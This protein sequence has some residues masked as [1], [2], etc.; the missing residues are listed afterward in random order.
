MGKPHASPDDAIWAIN[1]VGIADEINAMPDGLDTEMISAGKGLSRVLVSKII[2]AR[3]LAKR[4]ALLILSDYFNDLYL[5]DRANLIKMLTDKK[6]E[7]TLIVVSNDPLIMEACDRVV[8]LENGSITTQGRF[9]DL[10]RN[11]ELN[12]ICELVS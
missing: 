2:L 6:H 5:S 9:E 8:V 12:E 10:L 4:P 11:G 3:C 7:W 1:Q